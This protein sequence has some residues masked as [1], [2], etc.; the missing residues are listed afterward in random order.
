MALSTSYTFNG[1]GNWSLSTASEE[2][3]TADNIINGTYEGDLIDPT[4]VDKDGESVGDQHDTVMA[5]MGNDT[6]V[7]GR[8]DDYVDGSF[9]NDELLG[10]QGS[11]TL[12]GKDGDDSLFG[13]S[14][15]DFIEGGNG[16]D[17]ISGGN[18]TNTL[19]G[20]DGADTFQFS[21]HSLGKNIITDF[22]PSEDKIEI[23]SF[24]L[25]FE[26]V[27]ERYLKIEGS[28]F[29]LFKPLNYSSTQYNQGIR[30]QGI[31]DENANR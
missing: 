31:V 9:G 19:T 3:E 12:L 26:Y 24:Y 17:T 6:V 22:D 18:G 1:Y 14:G 20:G 10:S 28:D 16:N 29:I 4:Y 27:L 30:F 13:E 2:A 15:D 7:A 11:D 8:G 23:D 25:G 5:L 21:W